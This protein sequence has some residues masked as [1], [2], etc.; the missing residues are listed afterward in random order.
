MAVPMARLVYVAETAANTARP[1][2]KYWA[3]VIPKPSIS[4]LPKMAVNS[5][6][7]ING[8]TMVKNAA[9]GVR[10]NTLF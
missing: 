6:S 1:G 9:I 8:K 2:V 5:T 4:S 7:N 3:V 10:Q